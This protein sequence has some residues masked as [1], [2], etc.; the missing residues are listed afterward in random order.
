[1]LTISPPDEIFWSRLDIPEDFRIENWPCIY[2]AGRE[3]IKEIFETH[4]VLPVPAYDTKARLI[5]PTQYS[6]VLKDAVA[7]I[8][9]S[10]KHWA[11]NSVDTYVADIINVQ[12]VIPPNLSELDS[13]RKRKI[14]LKDPVN[15]FVL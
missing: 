13:P 10:L 11:I 12:I 2:D 5:E 4:C 15:T 3:A 1:M 8:R 7:V 14:A 6:R 9:F